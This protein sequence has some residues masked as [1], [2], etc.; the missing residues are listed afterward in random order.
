[1]VVSIGMNQRI[2]AYYFPQ[3]HSIP[4]ND[5]VFGHGFTDW[6]LFKQKSSEDLV[7]FKH[8][9]D[10]PEG[11]GYYDPTEHYIREKQ[12]KLAKKYGIDGF[13]YYHYWL[14]NKP[15]MGTVVEAILE[16][17]EPDIPFCLC[18]ANESW[19]H[20]YGGTTFKSFH[21]D[22]AT[23]RQLYTNPK[24][25]AQYLAKIVAH[26]NYIRINDIPILFVYKFGPEVSTYL[27][28]IR[29]ELGYPLYIIA[30]TS[31][32]CLRH[33]T[34]Q[35]IPDAYA[36]FDVHHTIHPN[37]VPLPNPLKGLPCV[38]GVSTGWNNTLRHPAEGTIIHY[39]PDIFVQKLYSKLITMKYDIHSLQILSVFAW[40]EWAEGA[41]LEPNSVYGEELGMAVSRAK[42]TAEIIHSNIF[43]KNIVFEY[44]L[45]KDFIDITKIIYT[46]CVNVNKSQSNIWITVEK[47]DY[48]RARLF[49]DPIPG[50]VKVIRIRFNGN[51]ILC[52]SDNDMNLE[53]DSSTVTNW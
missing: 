2:L 14:E 31:T 48:A 25:H 12:A 26:P 18:F 3:Y 46:Q 19:K 21:P 23:Y 40:N 42:N 7:E 20:N 37:Q 44:G 45:G 4:E 35:V 22:G 17:N 33:Y 41:M 15:V 43:I 24:E 9:I 47:C 53:I 36:P 51:E 8:P 34:D 27:D 52:N 1:M 11:L 5:E 16:D 38:Y 10:P 49:G 30:C 39:T 6:E 13:I 50:I 29:S 28:S 32:Y